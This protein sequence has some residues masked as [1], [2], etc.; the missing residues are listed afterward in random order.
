MPL[1]EERA[2]AAGGAQPSGIGQRTRPG[3]RGRIALVARRLA[4]LSSRPEDRPFTTIVQKQ[5]IRL[6]RSETRKD[7]VRRVAA[8]AVTFKAWRTERRAE[9]TTERANRS[10]LQVGLVLFVVGLLLLGFLA[11]A[12][13]FTGLQEAR[14]Q[15]H[16]LE[17]YTSSPAVREALLTKVQGAEGLPVAIL[18]VPSIGLS[19]VVV[20]GTSS[21]DLMSG[22]GLMP[23]TAFPGTKGN[24]VIAGR[25]TTAG[26]PFSNL[27]ALRRGSAIVVTTSLGKFDYK[28]THVGVATSGAADPISPTASPRLTLVTANPPLI[29]TGFAYVVAKLVTPPATAPIPKKPPSQ[30][31]T[32]LSGDPG[33]IFPSLLW[34]A[35]LVAGIYATITGYRRWENQEWVIYIV[36]TPVILAIALVWFGTIFRLLPAT[37]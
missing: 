22:P 17:E 21:T 25:R 34:G 23:N 10:L 36:S 1:T 18:D 35:L 9:P 27:P 15:R 30:S 26:A 20:R 16:L 4:G 8:P 32:G 5:N 31:Q 2:K 28:V 3:W 33:A 14:T 11:Y 24:S 6:E 7:R 29:S 37:L 19:Q 13:V 12:F